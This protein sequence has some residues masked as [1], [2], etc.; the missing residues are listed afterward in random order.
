MVLVIVACDVLVSVDFKI[1]NAMTIGDDHDDLD[2]D[3]NINK[4]LF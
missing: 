3:G 4:M 1:M 2:R